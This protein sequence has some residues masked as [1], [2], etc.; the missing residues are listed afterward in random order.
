MLI[1]QA[2]LLLLM[3]IV[4]IP[5]TTALLSEYLTAGGADART[6]A[7]VYSAVM[8]TMSCAFA[9]LY[10]YVARRPALLAEQPKISATTSSATL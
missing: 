8:L 10:G 6:A 4:A 2:L 5:F 1:L 3:T 7:L 9:V